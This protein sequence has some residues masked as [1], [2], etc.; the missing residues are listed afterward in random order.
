MSRRAKI[1]LAIG[2]IFSCGLFVQRYGLNIVNYGTPLPD[3]D[4][5]IGADSCM[6]YDPWARNY[7]YEASKGEAAVN[8]NPLPFTW[9]WLQGLHYRL[10]F[11]ITG[12]DG[13]YANY[14]PA[15]LP[16]ATAIVI[17]L[18]GIMG[19]LLY[20]RRVLL[21]RPFLIFLLFLSV[22]YVASLW[23]DNY[24]GFLETG[25]PVAING[26]YLV[27]VLLPMAAVFGRALGVVLQQWPAV[28]AGAAVL[29][30]ALFLQAGGVCS[31]IL[32][33]DESWYWPNAAV[34]AAN[35]GAQKVLDPVIF[36]GPKRY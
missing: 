17:G 27:L 2:L 19:L 6:S 14:P 4:A 1:W 30:I 15:P 26:R 16:S 29:A 32:R 24:M 25:Q 3:C 13:G 11:M 23:Y 9:T 31:F 35:E 18:F 33:S 20:W 21:G 8:A 5:V 34:K 22:F 28:R 7:R 36:Q 12:P 10:F